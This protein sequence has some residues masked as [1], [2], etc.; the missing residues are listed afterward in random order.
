MLPPKMYSSPPPVAADATV[1]QVGATEFSTLHQD[2]IESNV[3]TRLDGPSLA[4]AASC[5]T[6]LRHLS[7]PENLWSH[8]CHSTWPSTVSQSV[9]HVISKF[10]NGGPRAFFSHA[11]PLLSSSNLN[12]SSS[13]PP[14][15]L[16]SSVDIHYKDNLIFSKLQETETSTGWF[17]CSPFR[18]DLLEPKDVVPTQIKHPERDENCNR[19]I[20]DMRLSWILIDPIG[21]RAVNLS[22]QKP[23][24]VQR[25]WLT[26]EVQVRFA[27]ILAVDRGH[28]Q[29]GIVVTC[30]GSESGEMQVREVSMEME[31][32][33]GMHLNGK[34]SL[35]ILDGALEGR[36]GSG[37]N[38]VQE[39]QRRYDE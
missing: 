36:K 32:M 23:V 27:S 5:S 4:S 12:R 14:S 33:D 34:D 26:G 10:P 35:V 31:D 29:C 2:I 1:E 7:S 16:I 18:I 3:L 11:F 17:R 8:I 38:R 9:S 6:T 28:V 24:T 19:I 37:R 22:S 21:F 20:T 25:H 15:E 30:G 39:A 13:S